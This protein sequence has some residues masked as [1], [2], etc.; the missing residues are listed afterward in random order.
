MLGL[1]FMERGEVELAIKEYERGLSTPGREEE[2][3]GL[4]YNLARAHE[5][6]GNIEGMLNQL[7]EIYAVDVNYLDVKQRLRELTERMKDGQG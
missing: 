1:C 6:L 2:H 7:R 3:L 4:R 5:N